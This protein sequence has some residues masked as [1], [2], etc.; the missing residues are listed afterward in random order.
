MARCFYCRTL[1]GLT[2]YLVRTSWLY[3]TCICFITVLNP[4]KWDH[5]KVA[6][7]DLGENEKI[8]VFVAPGRD[9][10]SRDDFLVY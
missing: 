2:S 3:Q 7:S 9:L 10:S 1:E 8:R 4:R 6:K 5:N